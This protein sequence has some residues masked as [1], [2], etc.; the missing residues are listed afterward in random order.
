MRE[1]PGNRTLVGLRCQGGVLPTW[2]GLRQVDPTKPAKMAPLHTGGN[3]CS[4][5]K[6][7]GAESQEKQ[8]FGGLWRATPRYSRPH[9]SGTVDLSGYRGASAGTYFPLPAGLLPGMAYASGAGAVAVCGRKSGV[10]IASGATR[11]RPPNP[12]LPYRSKN[13]GSKPKGDSRGSVFPPCSKHWRHAAEIPASGR[14][15]DKHQPFGK[16]PRLRLYKRGFLS[17]WVCSLTL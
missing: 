3:S 2:H 17:S 12:P 16:S 10:H 7:C 1:E 9:I 15:G 14:P 4:D 13:S 5:A 8:L 11:Q 6:K